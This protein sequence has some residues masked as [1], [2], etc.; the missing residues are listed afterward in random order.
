MTKTDTPTLDMVSKRTI[1]I[2]TVRVIG[3]VPESQRQRKGIASLSGKEVEVIRRTAD[4]DWLLI[5]SAMGVRC[6]IHKDHVRAT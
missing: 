3:S 4:G 2:E 6:W 1:G 5:K